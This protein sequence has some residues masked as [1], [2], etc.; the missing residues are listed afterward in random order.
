MG[1]AKEKIRRAFIASGGDAA[2]RLIDA[3]SFEEAV[4]LIAK[5]SIP[6]DV[7]ILSPACAS[8]DMFRNFE[9]RG[10]RFEELV[11]AME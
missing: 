1:A 2:E 11:L 10:E 8:F 9:K 5:V 3:D 6:G 4:E 7:A